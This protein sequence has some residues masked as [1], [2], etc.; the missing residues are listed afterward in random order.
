[1]SEKISNLR[2]KSR[3]MSFFKTK[4][5]RA[6]GVKKRICND[7]IKLICAIKARKSAI[8]LCLSYLNINHQCYKSKF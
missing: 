8:A 2:G 4:Q 6:V 3:L 5:K 1:M 7:A